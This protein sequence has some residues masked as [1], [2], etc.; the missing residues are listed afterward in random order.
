MNDTDLIEHLPA[1]D[2]QPN[3]KDCICLDLVEAKI[4]EEANNGETEFEGR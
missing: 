1:C 2:D 4:D 3:D